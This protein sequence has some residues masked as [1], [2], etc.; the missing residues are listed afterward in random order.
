MINKPNQ[1]PLP[2]IELT[3][4]KHESRLK[5]SRLGKSLAVTVGS[6]T[7][8]AGAVK[9]SGIGEDQTTIG[10][11][12]TTVEPYPWD[13][14]TTTVVDLYPI[15]TTIPAP[16]ETS[17]TVPGTD[18]VL[19][20]PTTTDNQNAS[21]DG[22]GGVV[23]NVTPLLPSTT[24]PE[25]FIPGEGTSSTVDNI[26]PHKP[27]DTYKEICLPS[28]WINCAAYAIEDASGKV[29]T[30][31]IANSDWSEGA[32]LSIGGVTGNGRAVKIKDILPC[33]PGEC[34]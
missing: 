11:A 9:A 33:P 23:D 13:T 29:V 19:D 2:I 14:T 4:S 1:E 31:I 22:G 34:R 16:L 5:S 28:G 3:P 27:Q 26:Q 24:L 21:P 8:L 15:N 25:G 7:L 18:A 20:N 30:T 17:T 6:L 12:T 10:D 32:I